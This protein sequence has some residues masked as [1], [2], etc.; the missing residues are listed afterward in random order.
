MQM[1]V[2]NRREHRA[3]KVDAGPLNEA[4]RPLAYSAHEHVHKVVGEWSG[5]IGDGRKA[6]RDT[7]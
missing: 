7:N 1:Y 2:V 3:K 6:C 4:S 5:G